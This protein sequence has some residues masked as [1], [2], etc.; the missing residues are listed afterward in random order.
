M[1][2]ITTTYKKG[3]CDERQ[4]GIFHAPVGEAGGKDHQ[5]IYS[6][7]V[8]ATVAFSSLKEFLRLKGK[9]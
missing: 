6:P 7:N 5:V 8:R 4:A 3:G 2:I 9:R 1:L